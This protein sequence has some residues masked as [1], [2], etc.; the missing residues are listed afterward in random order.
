MLARKKGCKQTEEGGEVEKAFAK[1]GVD[2]E[3]LKRKA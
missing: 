1:G 2:K 3:A